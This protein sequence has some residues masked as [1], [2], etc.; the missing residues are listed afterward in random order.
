VDGEAVRSDLFGWEDQQYVRRGVQIF[1][2][3]VGLWSECED[4]VSRQETKNRFPLTEAHVLF[5][6]RD[7]D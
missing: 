5:G 7:L 6:A 3:A 2:L 4:L 1:N